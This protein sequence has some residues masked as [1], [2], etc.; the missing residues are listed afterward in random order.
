MYSF[1]CTHAHGIF[2]LNSLFNGS[3]SVF[4]S[5]G[6]PKKRFKF[7]KPETGVDLWSLAW[8]TSALP[9][10]GIRAQIRNI[11]LMKSCQRKQNSTAR[12]IFNWKTSWQPVP[13]DK[14]L[15]EYQIPSPHTCS[16][17]QF[18]SHSKV[19]SVEW[20][21]GERVG[22]ARS[23]WG[24]GGG[25]SPVAHCTTHGTLNLVTISWIE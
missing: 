19:I 1:T 15:K 17:Q 21:V 10:L 16:S 23:G 14:M 11:T 25:I 20:G 4:E 13:V 9:I 24:R 3:L 8:W 5:K 12:N 18:D 2:D 7:Y 22:S 6:K